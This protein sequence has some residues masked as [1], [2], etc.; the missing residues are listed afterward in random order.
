MGL[1]RRKFTREFK[2]AAI[3]PME[4]GASVAEQGLG[5]WLFAPVLAIRHGDGLQEKLGEIGEQQGF[6][7]VNAAVGQKDG[8]VRQHVIYCGGGAQ[9]GDAGEEVVNR[10][11]GRVGSHVSLLGKEVG[12]AEGYVGVASRHAAATACGVGVVATGGIV[13]V[14]H[15]FASL[16]K[17]RPPPPWG[18]L[19]NDVKTR[20][21][22]SIVL[23][24]CE[25][26]GFLGEICARM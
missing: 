7:Q 18:V 8:E 21:F 25:R 23:H 15:E 11:G 22:K 24:G 10:G 4:R 12:T 17:Y 3:D 5:G 26:K 14:T 20:G 2:L 19:R 13:C 6:A 1:S 16:L 9:V